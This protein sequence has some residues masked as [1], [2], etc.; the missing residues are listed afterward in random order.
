MAPPI[1]TPRP[2]V[3]AAATTPS[4]VTDPRT[5]TPG[6]T[7]SVHHYHH[8][9]F[10]RDEETQ[11]G[12][13][14]PASRTTARQ[15][16]EEPQQNH[17]SAP[18]IYVFN[19]PAAFTPSAL[20][21]QQQQ[22]PRQQ[23]PSPTLPPA[24]TPPI[25][26]LPPVFLP[27]GTFTPAASP[28]LQRF[29]STSHSVFYQSS[30]PQAHSSV[31]I[32]ADPTRSPRRPRDTRNFASWTNQALTPATTPVPVPAWP[33][34][35]AP[36]PMT[37]IPQT[38][39]AVQ[40]VATPQ[41]IPWDQFNLAAFATPVWPPVVLVQQGP[42]PPPAQIHPFLAPNPNY[43]NWASLQWD[44]TRSPLTGSRLTQRGV[45]VPAQTLF[46]QEA[47][48]PNTIANLRIIIEPYEPFGEWMRLFWGGEL[49]VQCENGQALTIGKILD[50]IHRW[51]STRLT[52]AEYRRMTRDGANISALTVA[53]HR[54]ILKTDQPFEMVRRQGYRRVDLLGDRTIFNGLVLRCDMAGRWY[55][56]L[57]L[58]T[59]AIQ[60]DGFSRC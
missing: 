41:W 40:Q 54:R 37:F 5:Q 38:P 53:A 51:F 60:R 28:R 27:N 18:N 16:Q 34:S 36:L 4:W 48:F 3:A 55:A 15:A 20:P 50:E 59:R 35:P 23:T 22:Q 17:A 11:R 13:R 2:S 9:H 43:R 47:L 33:A 19:T 1:V 45:T 56:V 30:E 46:P 42:S 44:V 58:T 39:V 21:Q 26:P 8:H 25:L 6:G 57:T 14:R 32:P 49:S 31:I 24:P 52:K 29:P 7:N 12:E 10:H